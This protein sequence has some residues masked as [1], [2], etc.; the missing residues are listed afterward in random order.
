LSV[1]ACGD[2]RL[3]TFGFFA[4]PERNL[5]FDIND[6]D[7]TLPGPWEWDVERLAAKG[8]DRGTRPRGALHRRAADHRKQG[9]G[10]WGS[11]PRP[12][13]YESG[14][15]RVGDDQS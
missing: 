9:W 1:Q 6:F 14:D 3:S 13:D 4:S 8:G 5:V 10:G 7:E 12:R 11:N 15:T 2:A